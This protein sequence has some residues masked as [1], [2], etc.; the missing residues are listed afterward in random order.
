MRAWTSLLEA[1]HCPRE[2]VRDLVYG[3]IFT[4]GAGDLSRT[5]IFIGGSDAA[6]AEA[7]LEAVQET[8][9]VPCGFQ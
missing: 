4:R 8:F 6:A 2:S 5:A 9:S 7:L 3:A 1:L